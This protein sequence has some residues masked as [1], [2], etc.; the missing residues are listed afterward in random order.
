MQKVL[1]DTGL[2]DFTKPGLLACE[3]AAYDAGFTLIEDALAALA[4]D[5]F[6]QTASKEGL[7]ARELLF[8]YVPSAAQ[9]AER[10]AM[11]LARYADSAEALSADK[12]EKLLVAAGIE[13]TLQERPDEGKLAVTARRLLGIS[14]EQAL[15]ELDEL[16]PAH[17]AIEVTDGA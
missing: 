8:R 15:R 10:R 7:D 9:P 11:L 17:L 13:G 2:Y 14:R 5:L 6:I 1:E 16:L 4:D 12:F 3:M